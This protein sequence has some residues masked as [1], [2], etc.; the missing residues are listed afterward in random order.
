MINN[1][2]FTCLLT[3]SANMFNNLNDSTRINQLP[4]FMVTENAAEKNLN[5]TQ[6]GSYSISDKQILTLPVMFGEP[7]I[8]KTLHT[9][10]GVSQGIEGFTGMYVRGGDNDQNLFL[11][12]GLPL[13][14]VSHL[15]GIF[16]SFNV[17]TINKMDFFKASFPAQYGGGESQVLPTLQ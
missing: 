2:V 5:S 6:M 12:Q 3:L 11:F 14:H 16:S 10:P 13:Y 9:L 8:V 17:A 4:E 1:I 15:G 7:D